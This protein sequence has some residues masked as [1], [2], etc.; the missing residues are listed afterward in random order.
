AGRLGRDAVERTLRVRRRPRAFA[1]QLQ[2]RRHRARPQRRG[3]Q[4]GLV[5]VT[6]RHRLPP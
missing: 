5:P 4:A 6:W 3:Q 2:L 1:G